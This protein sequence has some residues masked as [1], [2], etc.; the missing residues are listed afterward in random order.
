MRVHVGGKWNDEEDLKHIDLGS[1]EL[2]EREAVQFINDWRSGKQAFTFH[3]SGSTGAPKR[4]I[5]HRHQLEISA[6]ITI[7]ALQLK[8]GQTALVC[9]DTR[10]VAGTMMLVR[11]LVI[12]MNIII[13][14]PVGDPLAD[15]SDPVDFIAVVPLQLTAMLKESV[16]RL[17]RIGTVLIGGA[18]LDEIIVKSLQKRPGTFFATYGMTET[19]THVA[20]RRLNGPRKQEVF[21]LLPGFSATVDV[22]GCLMLRASHL[23]DDPIETNDLVEFV[24]SFTFRIHGRVDDV[25]NSGG[26]KIQPSKVEETLRGFLPEAGYHFRFFVAGVPD[27]RLGERVCLVVESEPLTTI[28]GNN[29]LEMVKERL[30]KFEWPR[31][32]RYA[33]SFLETSTQKVDRRATLKSI[34]TQ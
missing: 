8:P 6:R 2:H 19:L 11:S 24:D 33:K 30:E 18:P 14:K 31:E 23:G 10:F 7:E 4:I 28:E 32:I 29:L 16:S 12:S 3:T 1:L 21:H 26:V 9:L 15:V 22:R 17:D 5:F 34:N 20:L 27:D 25:I 13:R